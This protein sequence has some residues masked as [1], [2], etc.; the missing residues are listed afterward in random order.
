MP[1]VPSFNGSISSQGLSGSLV[2]S[3]NIQSFGGTFNDASSA[4]NQEIIEFANQQKKR[5][6]QVNLQDYDTALSKFQID[7]ES[8][9][10]SLKGKDA[11]NAQAVANT[12]WKAGLE[13]LNSMLVN[14]E[15]RAEAQR[16]AADRFISLY[17]TISTHTAREL[18]NY[19]IESTQSAIVNARNE[20]IINYTTPGKFAEQINKQKN[21]LSSFAQSYGKGDEWLE[22]NIKKNVSETHL[23]LITHL[24]NNSQDITASSH[25]KKFKKDFTADDLMKA[26]SIVE[27]GSTEGEA[28]RVVDSLI[29]QKKNYSEALS[30]IILKTEGNPKLRKSMRL[31]AEA[32]YGGMQRAEA[33]TQK[34]TFEYLND[35]LE[36][37]GG[38]AV[39]PK[40]KLLSLSADLSIAIEK[41]RE[42]LLSGFE[43][44]P[45]GETYYKLLRS[46]ADPET[47]S[48]A[49]NI[50][51]LQYKA[52]MTRSEWAKI[53]DLQA[54]VI[55]EDGKSSRILNSLYT[56]DSV[57][58]NALKELS[59][60]PNS[61]NT[62]TVK[63]INRFR[64]R[65]ASEVD[66]FTSRNG[67]EPSQ[68]D[69]RKIV[70]GLTK[71]IILD[72]G[73]FFDTKK[74]AYKVELSDIPQAYRE[75][76]EK[77]LR[78]RKI[79]VSDAN[80]LDMYIRFKNAQE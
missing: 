22:Q 26:E 45:G 59:I 15:Q 62:T 42:Q 52:D 48:T 25:F 2:T 80:I 79:P 37:S 29:K 71:D 7:L 76:I 19:D 12:G 40:D 24:V 34:Q 53:A 1:I 41:R 23:N 55:K 28:Q 5:F 72:K 13:S 30:E 16:L 54:G 21:L 10:L 8:E 60:D 18:E 58:D 74:K 49:K 50:N 32:Q 11:A 38:R 14:D 64:D 67:K 63:Q 31:E 77:N 70:D 6:D 65:V 68:Q 35:E 44:A 27:A 3:G 20:A 43:P 56:T 39:L 57:I 4:L 66:G 46:L 69:L 51:L 75:R 78:D 47:R 33:L 36:K 9:A 61:K 17:K 73:F